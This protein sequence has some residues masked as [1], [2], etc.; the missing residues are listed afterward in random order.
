MPTSPLALPAAIIARLTAGRPDRAAELQRLLETLPA[1]QHADL[2]RQVAHYSLTTDLAA[3]C[4]PDS[5]QPLQGVLSADSILQTTWP[6]PIWAIPGLLPVGLTILAGAP[7][8]GKSWLALQI[9]QAV[10]SGGIIFNTRIQRGPVLYLA[11][12]DP[13]RRLKERM[14]T[15]NWPLGLD[16]DFITVGNFLDQIGDLRN[17]GGER[18][19]RQIERRAYRLVAIDT[20]SRSIQGDQQDVREMTEW[21]SP[22]QEMAHSQ[23]SAIILVDHHKKATGFD[24]D[25]IS[26]ILGSTAK[27]AMADTVIGLYR[28]RGKSGAKLSITG[29]DVEEKTVDLVWDSSTGAWQ[30]EDNEQGMT[31]QRTDLVEI[32]AD[33][34]PARLS[35]ISDAV[36]RRRGNVYKQLAELEK[37][38]R[39]KKIGQSWRL[40]EKSYPSETRE[41]REP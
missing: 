14:L 6:E 17:G 38:G 30:L 19:A 16:A 13:P 39:V 8:V 36:G 20:L 31:P 12:E 7:K 24:P 11:L 40:A 15:Q 27:G 34:G 4:T 37:I 18:L 25:A 35:E 22:L 41:T 1:A 21:L 2:A 29:R 10:A 9:A 32:L 5:L 28:E 23:N 3:L 26:D 33:I